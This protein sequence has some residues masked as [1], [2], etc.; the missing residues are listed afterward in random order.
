MLN[1][2]TM[3]CMGGMTVFRL[4][5]KTKG[6]YMYMTKSI[7]MRARMNTPTRRYAFDIYRFIL[8]EVVIHLR[9]IV[10]FYSR[11]RTRN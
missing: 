3:M 4:N 8:N 1:L 5:R 2:R 10:A 11:F 6:D 9:T 7:Y